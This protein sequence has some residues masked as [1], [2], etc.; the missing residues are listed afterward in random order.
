MS[1]EN[2]KKRKPE[3]SCLPSAKNEIVAAAEENASKRERES[4]SESESESDDD[5]EVVGVLRP[6][7]FA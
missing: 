4:E 6:A 3:N 1:G 2:N 7:N 5:V